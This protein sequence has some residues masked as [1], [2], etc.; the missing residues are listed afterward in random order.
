LNLKTRYFQLS[1][2]AIN[3]L[4]TILIK[5]NI[6]CIKKINYNIYKNLDLK[7]FF[8]INNINSYLYMYIQWRTYGEGFRVQTPPGPKK[9]RKKRKLFYY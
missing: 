3:N 4:Y 1:I 6:Q 5:K 9:K 7:F 8:K 2:K